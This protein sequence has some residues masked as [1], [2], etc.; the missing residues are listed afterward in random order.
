MRAL[1]N[2]RNF[3]FRTVM[4]INSCPYYVFCQNRY[5]I[6]WFQFYCQI[7]PKITLRS[8]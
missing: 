8:V 1:V 2:V 7:W 5:F 6:V 4:I 3:M